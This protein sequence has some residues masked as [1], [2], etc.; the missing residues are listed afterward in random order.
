M[1]TVAELLRS[2]SGLFPESA[3]RDAEILLCHCLGKPRSWLYT[4]P[5][6]DIEASLAGDF[7]ALLTSRLQGHP[8]AHL[9]GRREFWSLNLRVNENTLIPRPET[10]TLVEWALAL[11]LPERA[12]VLD[13]GTGS[14]AI[15][16]ALAS[17]R[18]HWHVR[19][20]DTSEQAL[21]V[22][23]KNAVEFELT[24]VQ[25]DRS[26]WFGEMSGQR[27]H[28]AVSNPPYVE[29]GDVHLSTGDLRFEPLGALMAEEEGFS[30]LRILITAAPQYLH[31]GGW[32]LLEHGYNQADQVRTLLLERGFKNIVSRRD[33][34]GL[35]RISG[36]QWHA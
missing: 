23:R 30:D 20:V 1:P 21:E 8:I 36:G 26:D 24:R 25:F 32:L 6:S 12:A 9:I 28:L 13:L 4:W 2:A 22:A 33:L 16:L 27:F 15:A 10:E 3:R 31:C 5:E 18:P 7:D 14:G 29:E 17:E 19:A 34:A 35:E 11:T